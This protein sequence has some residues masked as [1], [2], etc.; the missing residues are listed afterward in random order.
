MGTTSL[1]H[2][3]VSIAFAILPILVVL[4]LFLRPVAA[5]STV[6]AGPVPLSAVKTVYVTGSENVVHLVRDRLEK[7]G[8][9]RIAARPEEADAVLTCEVESKVI[10]AKT[11]VRKWEARVSLADRSQKVIWSTK[12]SSTWDSKLA[13]EIIAQLKKDRAQSIAHD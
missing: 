11:A 3:P 2:A 6:S 4:T 5:Q 1:R 13:D 9:L 12:K 7:W 8:V 10:L